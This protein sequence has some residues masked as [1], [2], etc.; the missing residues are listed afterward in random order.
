[1]NSSERGQAILQEIKTTNVPQN[2]LAV[3]YLGQASIV[4]KGH[5]HKVI[6]IDPYL[7]SVPY[8]NFPPPFSGQELTGVDYVC[9]T[10]DHIDHLD[11]VTVKAMTAVSKK[12]KF[13]APPCCE[14]LLKTCGV[15]D[16]NI[17]QADTNHPLMESGIEIKAIPAA[18]ETFEYDNNKQH[19]FVGYMIDWQGVKLYHAGD[20]VVYDGLVELLKE[21]R[22]DLAF[23]PINGRDYFRNQK[24]II[25]NMD[26]REAAELAV[27]AEM[28]T[29][30][31]I[32]YDMFA[33][34]T[35]WPGRFIDYLYEHYPFQKSH[36]LARFERYI[37]VS[38][39]AI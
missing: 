5:D 38:E 35:E 3:W 23:L 33:G 15:A 18:H 27:A 6:A 28:N 11:P 7:D 30:I 22:I 10:H 1:M 36:V 21:E 37:F 13:I 20:T 2:M 39:K 9:I 4:I 32:H 12:T 8:R 24:N 26:V 19:R 14:E 29:V 34:N 16:E 31:P 17:I 25:G